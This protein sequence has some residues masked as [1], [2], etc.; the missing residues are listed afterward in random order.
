MTCLYKCVSQ[1]NEYC[2]YEKVTMSDSL[3][4]ICFILRKEMTYYKQNFN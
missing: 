4:Q 2:P 3:K 1:N